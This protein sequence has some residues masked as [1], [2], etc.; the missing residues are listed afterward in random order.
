MNNPIF[1]FSLDLIIKS[2]NYAFHK[3]TS[4]LFFFLFFSESQVQ[5]TSEVPTQTNCYMYVILLLVI[6]TTDLTSSKNTMVIP[7]SVYV[8]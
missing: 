7:R 3:L 4:E 5:A 6:S 2:A 1:I 8:R